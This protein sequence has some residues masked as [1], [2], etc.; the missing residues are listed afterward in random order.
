MSMRRGFALA[1][2]D[3]RSFDRR[4]SAH[5]HVQKPDRYRLIEALPDDVQ[6]ISRGS[7]VSYIGA[8]FADGCVVQDLSAFD[9]LLDFDAQSGLLTVEAGARI[10]D[11]VRFALAH[12]WL[13][14]VAPG[15]PRA[16]VG[17]C[18]AAD[19]HGK[20]PARRWH[21]SPARRGH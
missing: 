2:T 15:H 6:R 21:V 18:I 11:V 19:V 17:G 20:N 12:G 13:L 3:L 1:E 10:G 14:P 16:S 7:G 4:E 9:R 8:S 5:C